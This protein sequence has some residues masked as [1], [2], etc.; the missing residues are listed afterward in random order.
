MQYSRNI[1][2]CH[3]VYVRSVREEKINDTTVKV[4]RLYCTSNTYRHGGILPHREKEQ[5][6]SKMIGVKEV[7]CC[8]G[9]KMQRLGGKFGGEIMFDT[10]RC[11]SCKQ[12]INV[13][14]NVKLRGE[15]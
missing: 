12:T 9:K 15:P 13:V 1:A 6:V 7:I 11:D 14:F 5:T 2:I 3:L 10:Y 8:C 4:N